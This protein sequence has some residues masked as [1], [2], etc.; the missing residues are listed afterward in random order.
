MSIVTK[1]AGLRDILRFDNRWELIISRAFFRRSALIYNYRGMN[2]LVDHAGGD[3]NGTR[4]CITSSMYRQFLGKMNLPHSAT[5]LDIGANGGGFPLLLKSEGISLG[6]FVCVEMNPQTYSRLFYNIAANFPGG[7]GVC[8][9]QAA[10]GAAKELKISFGRGNTADSLLADK[11][12]DEGAT[13]YTINGTTLDQI[14]EHCFTPPPHL[15]SS[16]SAKWTLKGR[17]M[18]YSCRKRA[19]Y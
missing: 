6:R 4:A 18:K 1:L 11:S 17:N 3:E 7:R 16:T 12:A 2:I 5:L 13:E 10:T 19:R 15:E 14:A 8:L 9:N